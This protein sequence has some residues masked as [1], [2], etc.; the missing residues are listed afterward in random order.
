MNDG[1]CQWFESIF[2]PE[3]QICLHYLSLLKNAFV[4]LHF[5][6][7]S[8]IYFLA[9]RKAEFPLMFFLKIWVKSILVLYFLS[10]PLLQWICQVNL[11]CMGFTRVEISSSV[12]VRVRIA[13]NRLEDISFAV[14]FIS[15]KIRDPF[16]YN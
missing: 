12:N 7:S 1:N 8:S 2:S 4:I 16:S 9:K 11:T 3:E 15:L 5:L 6:P 13:S 14:F 10:H